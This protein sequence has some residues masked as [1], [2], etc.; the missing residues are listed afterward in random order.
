MKVLSPF[1]NNLHLD[2][3]HGLLSAQSCQAV[4][5]YFQLLDFRDNEGLDDL[6]FLAFME[7]STDLS[8]EHIYDVFDMLDLD[9]SASVEF[10]EFYLLVCMLVAIKDNTEKHF[11]FRHWR[12]VFELL[13]V[14]GSKSVSAEEF[15]TIGSL[16]GFGRFAINKIFDE[17]DVSGDRELDYDEFRMF[18]FAAIDAQAEIQKQEEERKKKKEMEKERKDPTAAKT[19][20]SNGRDSENNKM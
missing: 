11:M 17:F 10:D 16:I 18:T 5:E 4:L 9:G 12:T 13:D 20:S 6:Q 15:A 1:L 14:D 3:V 2:P 8:E 7:T 19:C